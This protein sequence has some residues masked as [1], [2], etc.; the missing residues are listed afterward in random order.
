MGLFDFIKKADINEGYREYRKLKKAMLIDVREKDEYEAGHLQGAR[1]IPVARI[2]K[3]TSGIQ[4]KD[5][6][7]FVY[8]LSGSRSR[9]AV[10]ALKKL[11]YTNVKNIGG[12]EG[13]RGKLVK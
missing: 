9:R 6:P 10:S 13:Y 1:N 11:G 2:D 7:L 5:M 12:I 3:A 4:D 8:C